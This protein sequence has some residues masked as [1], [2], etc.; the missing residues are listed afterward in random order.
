ML[1][2]CEGNYQKA[3]VHLLRINLILDIYF[4]PNH[5]KIVLNCMFCGGAFLLALQQLFIYYYIGSSQYYLF[6]CGRVTFI[7]QF[8]I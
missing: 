6:K 7:F 3:L 8:Q 1:L 5:N 4:L 2:V